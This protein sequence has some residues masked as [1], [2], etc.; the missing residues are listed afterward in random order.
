MRSGVGLS[1]KGE[2][3]GEVI[4]IVEAP[5]Y[6]DKGLRHSVLEGASLLNDER[7]SCVVAAARPRGRRD[8]K[9]RAEQCG[10]SLGS[11]DDGDD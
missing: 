4:G 9:S 5:R 7:F 3:R 10:D 11:L 8:T 1:I 2:G 6:E